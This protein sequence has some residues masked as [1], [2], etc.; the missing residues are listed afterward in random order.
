MG[1]YAS[2]RNP[3][4]IDAQAK[5]PD[6]HRRNWQRLRDGALTK[7]IKVQ[8]PLTNTTGA[9]GL[10]VTD[11]LA[12]SG[13]NLILKIDP[14]GGFSVD[15][16]G[17]KVNVD[18]RTLAVNGSDQLVVNRP[19]IIYSDN[20]GAGITANTTPQVIPGVGAPVSAD[21][22]SATPALL[23]SYI[24][25]A[26][27]T[28]L[29]NGFTFNM[30]LGTTMVQSIGPIVL[31]AGDSFLFNVESKCLYSTTSFAT[32]YTFTAKS[33]LGQFFSSAFSSGGS[34]T[35]SG[36]PAISFQVSATTT[37]SDGI[38]VYYAELEEKT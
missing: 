21:F 4:N 28:T 6:R 22:L 25:Y 8:S 23:E 17:L 33:A 24:T 34:A 29:G 31:A 10:N 32:Y 38:N 26:C 12:V 13:D 11:P 15:P 19:L 18:A 7:T 5:T 20:S 14:A 1:Q 2:T 35:F 9:I 3:N 27:F 36:T 16:A 30:F 37:N